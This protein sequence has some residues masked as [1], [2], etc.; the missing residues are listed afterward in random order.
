MTTELYERFLALRKQPRESFDAS[1][2][3]GKVLIIDGLNTYIRCFAA[4]PTMND[5]GEHIG[6]I[7]GFLKSVGA[8]IRMVKPTRVIIVFDG[9]G[10][11]QRRRKIFPD[12]KQNRRPG[13]RLNRTYDFSDV[14][15]EAESMKK[16]SGI[17]AQLLSSLPVITMAPPK[18]EAD[19]VIAYL[20]HLVEE[21]G[22]KAIIM[23]NDKDFLQIVNKNITIW[24]PIKKRMMQ[25]DSIVE[26]YG[27][28]PH[29]FVV[30]R[31]LDGD[32]SDNIPGIRGIGPKTAIK[33]FPQL[34]ESAPF[35]IK[36]LLEYAGKQEK[37]KLFELITQNKEVVERNY[38][39]MQLVSGQMSKQ[40]RLNVL[41]CVD[42]AKIGMEKADLV[43]MMS[44]N[45]MMGAFR[46]LDQWLLTTF[47]PLT[48]FCIG[49]K[50]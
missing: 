4:V 14:N 50:T 1:D 28:H 33:M 12:Y 29:N 17:L 27:I 26:E 23:S 7:T 40:T 20:A 42:S 37:G 10:G 3:F 30:F 15:A 6:G 38:K 49:S 25:V 13:K 47:I 21:R 8:A 31:A 48:R 9:P 41:R 18:V 39:L 45:L 24:N 11:S 19:D 35:S 32:K 22:G 34:C 36:D 16:Q 2:V 43:R 44:T 46:N 5:N